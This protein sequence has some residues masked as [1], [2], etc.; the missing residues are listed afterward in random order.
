[1][2]FRNFLVYAN[3]DKKQQRMQNTVTNV[4]CDLGVIKWKTI[5]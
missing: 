1:M 5:S 3:V 4:N 2:I